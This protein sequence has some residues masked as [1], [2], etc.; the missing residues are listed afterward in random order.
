MEGE[1]EEEEGEERERGCLALPPGPLHHR[2]DEDVGEERTQGWGL[3][4]FV[5]CVRRRFN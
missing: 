5:G 2:R 3:Q 1:N 4:T